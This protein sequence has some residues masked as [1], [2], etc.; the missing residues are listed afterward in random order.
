MTRR[1]IMMVMALMLALAF[2]AP[3]AAAQEAGADVISGKV[4][5]TMNSGGY[6][7]ARLDQNGQK[8]WV[9]MPQT[10]VTK[11]QTMSFAGGMVMENFESKTLKRKFDRIVFTSGPASGPAAGDA[12]PHGT[13]GAVPTPKEKVSVPKAEGPNA[14]TV[15]GI[16][17]N[18]GRLNNKEASVRGKVVKVS[19]GIMQRNWIHLQDGTGDAKKGT[20][21]LVVTSTE[22]PAVGDVITASGIVRKDKDFGGSYQ[23]KVLMEE[24]K[25]GK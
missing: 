23:Y 4:V 25:V 11:G 1:T 8:I 10:T 18:S 6:T 24:A 15:A 12:K 5:E 20:H 13:K 19:P 2:A 16:Y 17:K 3:H 21:N 9:A 14:Y 22:L 7:Y